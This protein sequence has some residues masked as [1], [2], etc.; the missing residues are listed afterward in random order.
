MTWNDF[1]STGFTR[2]DEPLQDTLQFNALPPTTLHTW[3][4][5]EEARKLKKAQKAVPQFHWDTTPVAN[6][7]FTIEEGFINCWS[8]LILSSD[9]MNRRERTFRDVNW[10][11]VRFDGCCGLQISERVRILGGI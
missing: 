8:D 4:S 7:E 6:Q 5:H 10:A 9:W 11:L 1:S 2:E 3:P